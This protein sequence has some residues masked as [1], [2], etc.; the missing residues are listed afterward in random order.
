MCPGPNTGNTSRDTLKT[1]VKTTLS[2]SQL[3]DKPKKAGRRLTYWHLKT[4][5]TKTRVKRLPLGASKTTHRYPRRTQTVHM[6][7]QTYIKTVKTTMI[8]YKMTLK[9]TF[10]FLRHAKLT[11]RYSSR[12]FQKNQ[13]ST[14]YKSRKV[15]QIRARKTRTKTQN[16]LVTTQ[17]RDNRHPKEYPRTAVISRFQR[18]GV[19]MNIDSK[20]IK[21]S[22]N[23]KKEQFRT[24]RGLTKILKRQPTTKTEKVGILTSSETQLKPLFKP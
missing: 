18:N 7:E 6:R 9:N 8:Y 11:V 12:T 23:K 17:I 15:R 10:E 21:P 5:I 20:Y 24:H 22:R 1:T 14:G 3:Y 4:R 2:R 19:E 16:K 13:A